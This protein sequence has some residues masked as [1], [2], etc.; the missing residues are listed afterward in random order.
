MDKLKKFVKNI[1]LITLPTLLICLFL[2]EVGLRLVVVVADPPM[3][4]FNEKELMYQYEPGEKEGMMSYGPSAKH[5]ANWRINNFGWNSLLDYKKEK[6]KPRIAVIGDSFIE[7][8]Q[9]DVDKSFPALM[10]V[11]LEKDYEVYHLGKSGSP[12]S[13]YLHISRYAAKHFDP[14]ILIITVVHND[15][16]E[17]LEL[18]NGG[19][20]QFLLLK[21]GADG[22]AEIAPRPNYSYQQYSF[23]KR[24][25]KKSAIVRYFLVNLKINL[26]LKQLFSKKKKQKQYNANIDVA[27][28]LEHQPLIRK[29]VNYVLTKIKQ[30]NTGRRVIIVMDAPRFDIYDGKLKESSVLFLHQMMAELCREKKIE[31]LDLS[32]SM[33]ADYRSKGKKFSWDYDAHWNEYG[34]SFVCR[35]VLE[36]LKQVEPV[37]PSEQAEHSEKSEQPEQ[38]NQNQGESQA[39]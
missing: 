9:V 14:D 4:F 10:G 31:L 19:N 3:S 23:F 35:Q 28:A 25:F 5:R 22:I 6:S 17:S 39:D 12:L 2:L 29:C 37:A 13:Q 38:E 1:F 7:A 30:E 16:L 26:T 20:T 18:F 34:H 36:Q 8:F 11:K 33:N 21:D 24:F 15:F 27:S 32:E